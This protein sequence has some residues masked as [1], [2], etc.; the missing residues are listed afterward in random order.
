[1]FRIAK[2]T[3]SKL[4]EK[5]KKR[6]NKNKQKKKSRCDDFLVVNLNELQ[7]RNGGYI[8]R[9]EDRDY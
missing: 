4:L 5:K 3:Q 1:M 8:S 7:S 6:Q 2:A 9:L